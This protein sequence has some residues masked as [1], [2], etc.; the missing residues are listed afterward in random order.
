MVCVYQSETFREDTMNDKRIRNTLLAVLLLMQS[1]ILSA[2]ATLKIT[3]LE[4]DNPILNTRQR[5]SR[6]AIVQ[7]EDE[8][9]KPVAGAAVVFLTPNHGPSAVFVNGAHS[10]TATTGADGRA[11]IRLTPNKAAG[12]YEI[13]VTASKNGVTGTTSMTATNTV[14]A[15]AAAGGISGKTIAI[16]AAVGGA[17]AVGAAVGLHG[18]GKTNTPPSPPNTPTNTGVVLVPGSPT[19]TAPR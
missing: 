19:V 2:E 8:N 16:L 7:V 15:A 18:G 1:S 12:K 9:R 4:G 3:I 11:V 13:H 10:V 17:A 6:E 5:V 14:P